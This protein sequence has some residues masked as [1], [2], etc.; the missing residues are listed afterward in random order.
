MVK[1]INKSKKKKKQQI[2]VYLFLKIIIFLAVVIC[3]VI[4]VKPF[5][6]RDSS[7]S[8]IAVGEEN[9]GKDVYAK[10]LL[11]VYDKIQANYWEKITDEQL[12]LLYKAGLEKLIGDS[13]IL[14][15]SDKKGAEEIFN[16]ATEKM[17]AEQ[18]KELT[19]NLAQI[20]LANLQPFGRSGLYTTKD[21]K[22]LRDNVANIDASI[23]LY[24]E[25]AVEKDSSQEEIEK[26]YQE[27]NNELEKIIN[28][29]IQ[30]EE[31]R[32][33]SQ[34]KK[35]QIDRAHETLA[36]EDKRENYNEAGVESTVSYKLIGPD[37]FYIHLKKMSPTT[38]DEFQAATQAVDEGEALNTL[39]FDL[40]GNVGGAIDLMQWFLGPFIGPDQ[41]AYEFYHR[42]DKEPFK[43]KIGWMPSLVR[44]KKVIILIDE[45]TQSS[46]E[47]MA[48]TLKKYNVG[49]VVGAPTKGWGT[50]ENVFPLDTQ[51]SESE[52]YSV[53][54]V[55]SVTLRDDG[56]PIEGR[57]VDPLININDENWQDQLYDYFNSDKLVKAVEEALDLD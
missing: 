53:F 48:A 3:L 12:S 17:E 44:Y 5:L 32:Q 20:V 24:K 4:V 47:I 19:A 41:Y 40:R 42:G 39:I 34:K 51:L 10:F 54:L 9:F 50:V 1:K 29:E 21:E 26:A 2:K 36:D 7:Q 28:D 30:P 57:G 55:H 23:D 11:E 6:F 33:A 49:V 46:A 56:Q 35:A 45:Q 18:K 43:T 22:A 38:F 37:I 31:V 8:K 27:K 25:L 14:P 13:Y 15:S 52:K 16:K